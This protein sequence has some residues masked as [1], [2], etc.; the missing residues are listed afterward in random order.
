MQFFFRNLPGFLISKTDGTASKKTAVSEGHTKYFSFSYTI[1]IRRSQ[2]IFMQTGR[3]KYTINRFGC[4]ILYIQYLIIVF[5][6][7]FP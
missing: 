1:R 4:I 7:F 5:L 6:G 2:D 3:T